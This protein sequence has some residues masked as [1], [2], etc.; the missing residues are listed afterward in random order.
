MNKLYLNDEFKKN[1][2]GKDPFA[3]VSAIEGR[4]YRY[5]AGRKTFQFDLGGKSFFAKVHSGVGWLEIFK[6]L[7][8]FRMPVLGAR[9]EWRAI[10]CL[11][12]LGLATMT[13]VAFAERGWNPANRSSFIV[14]EDLIETSSLEDVCKT[15]SVEKPQFKMKLELVIA[16]ATIARKLH[17]NGICH[18]DFY[19]CHFLRH[20]QEESLKLSLIDLHRALIKKNL[21]PRWM[22]K[23]VSGLY[24][25]AMGIELTQRDLFRFM[26][27]YDQTSLRECLVTR[28]RFWLSVQ[29]R[30]NAMYQ[31]LG[32]SS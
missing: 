29:K 4:I 26:E 14:T 1:W 22:I 2:L 19:L 5:V 7:V 15:W 6:N 24:Y 11:K 25:S 31:K 13:A 8:Q 16:V 17:T 30:A 21:A 23:D 20:D 28:N 12:E 27:H 3:A 18:R 32:P 9:N 10:N